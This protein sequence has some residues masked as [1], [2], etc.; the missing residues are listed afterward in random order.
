MSPSNNILDFRYIVIL[1]YSASILQET[2]HEATQYYTK[3]YKT[4]LLL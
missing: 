1:E 4:I 3:V 2:V